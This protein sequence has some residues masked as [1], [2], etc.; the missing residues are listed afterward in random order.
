MVSLSE[1]GHIGAWGTPELG[2]TETISNM[3]G[4]GRTAEGG[5]NLISD[6]NIPESQQTPLAPT[7]DGGFYN[8]TENITPRTP[9]PRPGDVL[10]ANTGGGDTRAE[11]LQKMGYLNPKQKEELNALLKPDQNAINAVYDPI[12]NFLSGEE[13]RI[14]GQESN[15]LQ[16]AQEAFDVSQKTLD[17]SKEK[18]ERQLSEQ[19]IQ[20]EQARQR[21]TNEAR[22]LYDELTQGGLQRF[23][24]ASSASEAYKA[25]L[26]REQQRGSG[27]IAQQYQA[28]KRAIQ[29]ASFNLREDYTNKTLALQ[30]QFRETQNTI[31]NQFQDRLAQIRQM[32][33][34][35]QGAKAN[36]NL[37]ALEQYRS[38]MYN[39]QLATMQYKQQLDTQ[40][41]QNAIQISQA[42]QYWDQLVGGAQESLD[43]FN[44]QT[45]GL[46]TTQTDIGETNTQ[47]L[48]FNP[49]GQIQ[50]GQKDEELG[51]TSVA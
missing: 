13:S 19:D 27:Q 20:A 1:I 8:P 50:T 12:M 38:Q 4:Q 40:A 23:G 24:G 21:E 43:I 11:Q 14:A 15:V 51:L 42:N 2:I 46:P 16:S 45:A 47:Q 17:T 32:R 18:G 35:T 3:F 36:A 22:R 41:Q 7:G 30:Q 5:S 44:T 49:I 39:L 25:I 6:P 9:T 29:E 10:D 28:A 48:A 33:A 37:Q 26:G 31:R 34:S